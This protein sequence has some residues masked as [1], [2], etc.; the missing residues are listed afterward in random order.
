MTWF[1]P[2]LE[3]IDISVSMVLLEFGCMS[4]DGMFELTDW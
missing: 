1:F 2:F 4:L 3:R